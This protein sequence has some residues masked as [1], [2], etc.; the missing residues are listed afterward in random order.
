MIDG[1]AA[2]GNMGMDFGRNAWRVT[3]RGWR[4]NH[5]AV[6]IGIKSRRGAEGQFHGVFLSAQSTEF[7]GDVAATP[8]AA[9]GRGK[10]KA[11]GPPAPDSEAGPTAAVKRPRVAHHHTGTSD[12]EPAARTVDLL[13]DAD[14]GALSVHVVDTNERAE[15]ELPRPVSGRWHPYIR[16]L[17]AEHVARVRWLHPGRFGAGVPDV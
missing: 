4:D 14:R 15:W 1:H 11:S 7:E 8:V 3:V 6:A 12:P 17:V 9:G 5:S 10:R 2:Y 16:M 13:L